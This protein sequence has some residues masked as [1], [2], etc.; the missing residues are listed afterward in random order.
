MR[1]L[2]VPDCYGYD[3]DDTTVLI[4]DGNPKHVQPTKENL[5]GLCTLFLCLNN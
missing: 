4:D 1:L 2:F 5:V 3:T